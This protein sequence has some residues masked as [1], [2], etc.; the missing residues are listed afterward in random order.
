MIWQVT[1]CSITLSYRD[2]AQG[3][4]TSCSIIILYRGIAQGDMTSCGMQHYNSIQKHCPETC[5]FHTW[6]LRELDVLLYFASKVRVISMH[7]THLLWINLQYSVLPLI[8]LKYCRFDHLFW[9]RAFIVYKYYC[10][11]RVFHL[12]MT[13][14]CRAN[15]YINVNVFGLTSLHILYSISSVLLTF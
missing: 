14:W 4:M 15:G 7:C 1:A 13:V 12:M 2:I 8:T 9:C 10:T 3:D 6:P 11:I 5:Q